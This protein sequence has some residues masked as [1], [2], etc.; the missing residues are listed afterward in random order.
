MDCSSQAQNY[1]TQIGIENATM[2]T[3]PNRKRAKSMSVRSGQSGSVVR[4]GQMWHGRYYVDV[5]NQETRRKASVPLGSIREMKKTEA[6]R[7]L[8]ALL[9]EM[10]LNDDNHLERTSARAKT[11]G[12]EAAWWK[13]NRLPIFKPSCIETMGSHL[14]K[15]LLPTFGSLPMAAIDERRVQEFIAELIRRE[16]VWPNGVSKKISPKTIRNIIGVLRLIVGEK[17]WRE[18][19]LTLPEIPAK[20][21]RC[22]SPDEMRQVVNAA[23][24][25]WKM[26]FAT[27]A[28]TGMRCGEAFG[29]HVDD[30]DFATGRIFIR[31]SVWNGEEVS[32]KTKKGYRVVNIEP[33]LVAMLAA[34]LGDRKSG[35][36]FET[37]TGTPFCK[38]NV[39]RKL[40]QI[41]KELNLKPAGLHA[42]RHGRVSVL[43]ANGVPGDLLKEW[44]GHTN[45]Q[46]T[47]LYTHFQ[48]SFR[49]RVVCSVALFAQET[50][51]GKL[52]VGP[53][54]PKIDAETMLSES[55]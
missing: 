12:S 52:P 21:Q 44:I 26:L 41:L 8:R 25:Q 50:V 38:S 45:L 11:F 37:S 49:N 18:W 40:N 1:S 9:E 4:K 43:Q 33:V 51:A 15:Y 31:R 3:T 42:F 2:P 53:N 10:G 34:H 13:E 32:T 46:T 7:K 16:Y 20:E 28:G 55:L 5:P 47:S 30:L 48:D 54:G 14:E 22:F 39:R 27:L 6:K 17:V 29:L 36:V 35:R 23:T 19:K 24:G